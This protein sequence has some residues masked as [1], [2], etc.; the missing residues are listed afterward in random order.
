MADGTNCPNDR[1]GYHLREM[2]REARE[3]L[4]P[5]DYRSEH[6]VPEIADWLKK[7]EGV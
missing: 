4:G 3:L 6:E 5:R 7:T 1:D 2:V